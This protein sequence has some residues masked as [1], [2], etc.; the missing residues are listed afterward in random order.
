[1]R[2]LGMGASWDNG[3]VP[4]C[5]LGARMAGASLLIDRNVRS[6]W[7]QFACYE[8]LQSP[9]LSPGLVT[10]SQHSR[11]PYDNGC[12]NND[13]N[14]TACRNGL[15]EEAQ[16]S[17][18]L[19]AC[20]SCDVSVLPKPPWINRA[21]VIGSSKRRAAENE[22]GELVLRRCTANVSTLSPGEERAARRFGTGLLVA[23]KFQ[24]LET[25][26]HQAGCDIIG[27]QESRLQD[28]LDIAK[29]HYRVLSS[30]ATSAGTHGVMWWAHLKLKLEVLKYRPVSERI[31]LV[32]YQLHQIHFID[33]VVHAPI[34][35]SPDSEP[36]YCQL[37][38][39]V[40]EFKSSFPRAV[41]TFLGDFNAQLGEVQCQY[42]GGAFAQR[43]NTNGFR[44][45][46]FASEQGTRILNTFW[47]GAGPTWTGSRGHRSRLDYILSTMLPGVIS[48]GCEV[49]ESIELCECERDDHQA[50]AAVM[51]YDLRELREYQACRH[52]PTASTRAK[53]LR[54]D[55]AK[56]ADPERRQQYEE[57]V[58]LFPPCVTPNVSEYFSNFAE[59]L[60]KGADP[61]FRDT[62]KPAKKGWLQ[63]ATLDLM[64]DRSRL[65]KGV[66]GA[67]RHL[68]TV[69]VAEVWTSWS[70][71]C[72]S[73]RRRSELHRDVGSFFGALKSAACKVWA[74]RSR[75]YGHAM[76]AVNSAVRRGRDAFHD[77]MA[78]EANTAAEFGDNRHLFRLAKRV[79][80]ISTPALKVVEWEDGSLTTSDAE[81]S[82]RFL[83]H[84]QEVFG[85]RRVERLPEIPIPEHPFPGAPDPPSEERIAIATNRLK[86][87]KAVGDDEAPGELLKAGGKAFISRFK[88]GLDFVWRYASWPMPWRGGRI[89]PLHKKGSKRVCNNSRGLLISSHMGKTAAEILSD[90]VDDR[91][92][93]H[94]PAQQC[95]ATKGK[96]TDFPN[97]LLR[98]VQDYAKAA[99][100][101]CALVFV[102]LTKA[103]DRVIREVALGW[104]LD[105]ELPPSVR[106]V[107]GIKVLRSYGLS[108]ARA[109]ALARVIEE[110]HVLHEAGVDPHTVGLLHSMHDT[111]W[112]RV[113]GCSD[114]L[115]SGRGG[116]Q[117]CRY[118]SILFNLCYSKALEKFYRDVR[119]AGIALRISFKRGG[120]FTVAE[121][122]K[123]DEGWVLDC[124]FV[125]DEAIALIASVPDTLCRHLATVLRLLKDA[126][127]TFGF[128]INWTPGKTEAL[129][130]LR[131]K[132]ARAVKA[133]LAAPGGSQAFKVSAV[134]RKRARKSR[135]DP[136]EADIYLS[137]VR[138]YKH[139]GAFVE[140]NGGYVVEARNR[141]RSAMNAF[142]PLGNQNF[143]LTL[144]LPEA[145]KELGS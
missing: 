55:R 65:K 26:F 144:H 37:S 94:V 51:S 49:N 127:E 41:I 117:G 32:A 79:G 92:H 132:C 44:L 86:S 111:S 3:R 108:P 22:C 90:K 59:H 6:C 100:K 136:T 36:F 126:F 75:A 131:G 21:R 76:R 87:G 134:R 57:W 137:V 109:R 73:A 56:L 63:T 35:G 8:H 18:W 46:C 5:R 80:N 23:G 12:R 135:P 34:E 107:E 70:L 7:K 11:G 83:Q 67:F 116:R 78:E 16:T 66:R 68:Q 29:K 31:L 115:I 81:Y 58:S 91:Y 19:D 143:W 122:L 129:L 24:R 1:M 53:P 104:F 110:A 61:L 145:A 25:Q 106:V 103:F 133:R 2:S 52:V 17:P 82:E 105:P 84:F 33:A 43:E 139:L 50:V 99:K 10:T 40:A 123:C 142:A 98:M 20:L 62:A 47:P 89:A 96:G 102:D 28:D 74:W 138:A 128:E 77:S 119:K 93:A 88:S 45:R 95:G 54:L 97:H 71:L 120:H 60:R 4:C 140:V 14:Y 114:Y 30:S 39:A 121:G 69:I 64:V 13:A 124:T 113:P 48:L 15:R 85:A 38:T 101:S 27:V 42:V 141:E 130:E 118:G 9:E 72:P 112:F 125:D